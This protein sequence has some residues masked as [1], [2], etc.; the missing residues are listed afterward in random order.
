MEIHKKLLL[1]LTIILASVILYRLWMKRVKIQKDPDPDLTKESF[2]T[3]DVSTFI[4]TNTPLNQYCIKASWNTA[5]T[6]SNTMDLSMVENVIR[7]GCRFLDF[8]IY[9]VTDKKKDTKNQ[10]VVG[11][12]IQP[13]NHMQTESKN[14]IPLTE[15]INTVIQI[16]NKL[17]Y[18]GDPLFIQLRVKS[19][20]IEMYKNMISLLGN[21]QDKNSNIFMVNSPETMNKIQSTGKNDNF[22]IKNLSEFKNKIV[23]IADTQNSNELFLKM[24]SPEAPLDNTNTDYTDLKK[25][26]F[27]YFSIATWTTFDGLGPLTVLNSVPNSTTLKLPVRPPVVIDISAS[28]VKVKHQNCVIGASADKQFTQSF[29]DFSIFNLNNPLKKDII[30]FVIDYG[31]NILPIRFYI[32][33]NGLADYDELFGKFGFIAISEVLMKNKKDPVLK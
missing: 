5:Y 18:R 24:F 19:E 28:P 10:P 33:D 3:I 27:T 22:A 9:S 13:G 30:S 11:F 31:I 26:Y 16:N 25:K 23:L 2:G 8:E 15:I 12:S 4:N 20:Q 1:I 14:T 6:S 29:P 7:H 17:S 32:D 21:I